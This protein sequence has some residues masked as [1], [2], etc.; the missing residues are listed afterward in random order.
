[1]LYR[2]KFHPGETVVLNFNV[3]FSV[4]DIKAVRISFRGRNSIAFEATAIGFKSLDYV[5]GQGNTVYKTR[6]GYTMTQSESLQFEENTDY[7][8]QVNV[9]GPN[10]SRITSKEID[11]RT[12]EQHLQEP[13]FTADSTIIDGGRWIRPDSSDIDYNKLINKP[14]VNEIELR[15]N[16]V[17]PEEPIKNGEI[18]NILSE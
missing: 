5:D 4:L 6:V 13:G 9:Y 18:N 17:L 2:L 16:R 3:P 12:L 8:M 15:G 10:G 14:K 1:M 7:K 11:V